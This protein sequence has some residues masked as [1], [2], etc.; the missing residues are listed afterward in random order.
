[1]ATT[2][3]YVSAH[4]LLSK[5]S[6]GRILELTTDHEEALGSEETAVEDALAYLDGQEA[7]VD[8]AALLVAT[9]VGDA[10]RWAEGRVNSLAGRHY[11]LPLLNDDDTV[12]I[13]VPQGWLQANP[14]AP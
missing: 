10:L 1:M 13:E 3:T 7:E 8:A 4:D 11:T 9:R 14:I 5:I 6:R 12:P 2:L